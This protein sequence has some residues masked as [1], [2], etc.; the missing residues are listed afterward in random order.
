[1]ENPSLHTGK[2]LLVLSADDSPVK[3]IKKFQYGDMV[4]LLGGH[5]LYYGLFVWKKIL[6]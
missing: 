6:L 5:L 1:M 4:P 2:W 3:R